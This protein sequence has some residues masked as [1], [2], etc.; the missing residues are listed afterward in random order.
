MQKADAVPFNPVASGTATEMQVLI[1]P[2]HGAPNFAMRRF[3]MDA[4]GG[5]P[6]HTNEVEHEQYVLRGRARVRAGSETHEVS[7]GNVRERPFTD[8]WREG[9]V[10]RLLRRREETLQGKC[11]GCDYRSICGGCRGRALAHEGELMAAD[12]SCFIES[13]RTRPPGNTRQA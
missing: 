2:D 9:E 7:A 5:M 12:P 13:P 4:G 10:F 3:R 1:G 6:L 8:I 11:G